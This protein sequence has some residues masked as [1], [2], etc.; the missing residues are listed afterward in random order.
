MK[1][2]DS[3]IKSI[4][5][6][7]VAI[8]QNEGYLCFY[9]FTK[10][11]LDAYSANGEASRIRSRASSGIRFDFYT[12]AEKIS[13]SYCLFPGSSQSKGAF[14]FFVDGKLFAHKGE[15]A[16]DGVKRGI[17]VSL[18]EG[19][20]RLTV[21]F[22]T[23]S[24]T[25]ITSVELVG[26]TFVEPISEKKTCVFFGDSITQ[27][28]TTEFP[29]L[30]YA[31]RVAREL[32][33]DF[34]NFGVG[35]DKFNTDVLK[36]TAPEKPEIVFTAYGTNDW[37][38]RSGIHSFKFY[39]EEYFKALL[40]K[41]PSSRII[42]ISPIWREDGCKLTKVGTFEEMVTAYFETVQKFP[43]IEIVNGLHLLPCTSELYADKI[44]HPSDL[45]FEFYAKNLLKKIEKT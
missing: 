12:D 34:Y 13:V 9:R 8:F 16:V 45:G 42:A 11:V 37:C 5:K 30:C 28:Y 23:L 29:S 31:A 35:A 39:I 41:F 15:N 21:Y 24:E 20:K 14:D 40:E 6:G 26:E 44:L 18:P 25:K 7:A 32:D 27:G 22:P 38:A 43:R 17:D 2:N 3:Q 4:T 10:E 33:F 36:N 1:L 19:K